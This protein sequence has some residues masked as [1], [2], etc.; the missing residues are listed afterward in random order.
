MSS[1]QRRRDATNSFE[2]TSASSRLCGETWKKTCSVG[3]EIDDAIDRA[4]ADAAEIHDFARPHDAGGFR[5]VQTARFVAGAFERADFSCVI[6]RGWN[7]RAG[8]DEIAPLQRRWI[9]KCRNVGRPRFD[10]D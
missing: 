6:H 4:A 8:L 5:T 3:V 1:P 2:K 9:V 10:F 7:G